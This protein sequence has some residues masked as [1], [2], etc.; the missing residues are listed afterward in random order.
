MSS[1]NFYSKKQH[2]LDLKIKS[3]IIIFSCLLFCLY[4]FSN[5]LI[6]ANNIEKGDADYLVPIGN[7]LQIDAELK[8]IIVRN[9]I[10]NSPFQVGDAILKVENQTITNYGEFSSILYSLPSDCNVKLEVNRSGNIVNLN[11]KKEILEKIN[12]NNLI[13]GFA[14]LTYIN[15]ENNEFGA[16]GHPINVGNSR[17]IP[18]KNGLISTTTDIKVQKSYKG[19]VGAISARRNYSIGNFTENTNFGIKGN[20]NNFDVSKLEKYKVASLDEIHLGKAE[21]ILQ[22]QSNKCEKYDIEIISIERQKSPSPKTFKIRITDKD[23][24]VR[25]GGIVQGMSGT[26]I[27]QGDKIIGAVSHAVENDPTLGYGVFIGWMMN[28]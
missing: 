5:N 22:N 21:I 24:L 17:K 7:V 26:P 23:L 9:E 2:L 13:S 10:E 28:N 19:N 20:I 14:T 1:K 16:V 3:K 27:V 12:F 6:Y 25:T 18:I 15:P 4:F 11:C 8:T